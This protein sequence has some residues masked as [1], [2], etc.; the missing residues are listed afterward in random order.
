MDELEQ[1]RPVQMSYCHVAVRAVVDGQE[2]D[3]IALGW[4]GD[5]VTIRWSSGVGMNHM[6]VVDAADVTRT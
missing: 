6:T 5:R 2:R 3:A 1:G 4:A